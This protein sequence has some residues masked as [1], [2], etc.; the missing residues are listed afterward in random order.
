MTEDISTAQR[1]DTFPLRTRDEVMRVWSNAVVQAALEDWARVY[2]AYLHRTAP[3]VSRDDVLKSAL[4]L[5][6]TLS[7]AVW[8]V[9]R[10]AD[11]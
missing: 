3:P 9:L 7:N 11:E 1:P 4:A 5:A 2:D 6:C 8:V 10:S